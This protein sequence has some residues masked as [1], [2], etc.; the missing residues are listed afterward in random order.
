MAVKVIV[1]GDVAAGYRT[2]QH[3]RVSTGSYRLFRQSR[4]RECAAR[5]DRIQPLDL[6]AAKDNLNLRVDSQSAE[7]VFLSWGSPQ[8]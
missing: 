5:R 7:L 3:F 8:C 4:S 2:R 6:Q 1:R